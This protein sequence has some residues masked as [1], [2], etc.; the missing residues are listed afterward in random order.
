[1]TLHHPESIT[2]RKVAMEMT[3]KNAQRAWRDH[4][5]EAVNP[6]AGGELHTAWEAAFAR[7]Q[8]SDVL[9]GSEV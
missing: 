7:A 4:G 2:D 5:A 1:M 6:F 8:A 9:E 3:A